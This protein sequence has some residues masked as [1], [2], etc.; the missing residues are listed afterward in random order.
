MNRSHLQQLSLER[1][2]D[3]RELLAISRWSAAY[4]L[5]GYSLECALKSCVLA[6]IEKTGIIFEDKKF[7]ERCWTHDNEELVKQANLKLERDKAMG[8]NL[9]L[10]ENWLV[11]RDWSE[12]SRYRLSQQHDAE[13]LF[14]ALTDSVNGVLPWVKTFW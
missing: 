2:E 8:A 14:L 4:Y 6:Y 7:A 13:N 9:L 5:A 12:A 3:A 10:N 11:V 1:I